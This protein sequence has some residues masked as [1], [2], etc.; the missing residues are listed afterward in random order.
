MESAGGSSIHARLFATVMTMLITV[1]PVW[2]VIMP[3]P[4][5]CTS[6]RGQML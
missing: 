3:A 1:A 6:S 5:Q 4:L 2:T